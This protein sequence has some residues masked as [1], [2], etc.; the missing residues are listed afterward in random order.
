MKTL[1][2][3]WCDHTIYPGQL[4]HKFENFPL[5]QPKESQIEWQMLKSP[6]VTYTSLNKMLEKNKSEILKCGYR[7]LTCYCA[8]AWEM[9]GICKR[10]KLATKP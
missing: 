10:N 8:M 9:M 7:T 1:D 3:N 4:W 5:S 2:A 6:T